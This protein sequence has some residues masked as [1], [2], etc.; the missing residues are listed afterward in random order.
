M[1]FRSIS[2][3]MP[4]MGITWLFGTFLLNSETVACQYLFAIFNSIQVNINIKHH[5]SFQIHCIKDV[6]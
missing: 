6:M 1:G 5:S 4:V 3:L 2:I